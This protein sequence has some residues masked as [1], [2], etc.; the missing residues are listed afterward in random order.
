MSFNFY[1][2]FI[3]GRCNKYELLRV[4]YGIVAVDFP[5]VFENDVLGRKVIP[6]KSLF[7]FPKKKLFFYLYDHRGGIIYSLNDNKVLLRKYFDMFYELKNT[8]WEDDTKEK[9]SI[10]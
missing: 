2:L 9:L 7:Y 3:S 6:I 8:Y 4:L 1:T 5:S 10:Q